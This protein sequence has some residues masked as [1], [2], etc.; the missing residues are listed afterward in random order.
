MD[1]LGGLEGCWYSDG[2]DAWFHYF[3]PGE[4]FTLCGLD[5]KYKLKILHAQTLKLH[6]DC[7]KCRRMP[8]LQELGE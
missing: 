2:Q 3:F 7:E 5:I 6:D 8:I 4:Q 1:S